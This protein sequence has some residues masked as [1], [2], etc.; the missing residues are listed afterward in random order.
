MT[1]SEALKANETMRVKTNEG[2][3]NWFEVGELKKLVDE[4]RLGGSLAAYA[5]DWVVDKELP[6]V[7]V[8]FANGEYRETSSNKTAALYWAQ[9]SFQNYGLRQEIIMY[10][11]VPETREVI[12]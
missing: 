12:E 2:H 1:F 3:S 4:G 7:W 5:K 6:H 10:R 11:A 9:Q 8:R